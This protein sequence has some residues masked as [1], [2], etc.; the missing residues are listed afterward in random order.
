M[1]LLIGRSERKPSKHV[2]L[3]LA[4]AAGFVKEPK[5]DSSEKEIFDRISEFFGANAVITI[6]AK[7]V[8]RWDELPKRGLIRSLQVT[9]TFPGATIEQ[10]ASTLRIRGDGPLQGLEWTRSDDGP[11][12]KQMT[13][14]T[15]QLSVSNMEIAPNY[16]K[17]VYGM[18]DRAWRQIV[19][20]K[21]SG[22]ETQK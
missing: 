5:A 3:E 11:D 10:T 18:A 7:Y 2:H 8:I 4:L 20:E 17:E 12:G 13:D 16:M 1:R 21:D 6:W 9:A 15:L 19:L 22:E 14:I